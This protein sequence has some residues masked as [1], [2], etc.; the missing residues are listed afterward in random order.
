MDPRK[1]MNEEPLS[2]HP[3]YEIPLSKKGIFYVTEILRLKFYVTW[4]KLDQNT[5]TLNAHKAGYI[6]NNR[7]QTSYTQM[8]EIQ[9]VEILFDEIFDYVVKK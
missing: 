9:T 5:E 7:L 2:S 1:I 3:I 6:F 4:V 8:N